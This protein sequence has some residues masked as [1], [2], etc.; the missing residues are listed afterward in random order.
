MH[1]HAMYEYQA[2]YQAFSLFPLKGLGINTCCTNTPDQDQA[3]KLTNSV[4]SV[5]RSRGL[6]LYT[7]F[8]HDKDLDALT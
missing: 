1:V 3:G 6:W 4:E 7:L 2:S 5:K 8:D